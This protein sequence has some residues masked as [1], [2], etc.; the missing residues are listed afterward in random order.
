MKMDIMLT[1]SVLSLLMLKDT[2]IL[3]EA[4]VDSRTAES[5]SQTLPRARPADTGEC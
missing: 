2:A 3:L 5:P 1:R 4:S